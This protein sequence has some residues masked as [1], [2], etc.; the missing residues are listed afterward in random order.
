MIDQLRR[1]PDAPLITAEVDVLQDESKAY[2][3]K[4]AEP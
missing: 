2:A 1:L 3:R 4:L